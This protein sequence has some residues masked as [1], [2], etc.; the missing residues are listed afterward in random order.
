MGGMQTLHAV[1]S[2]VARSLR[3]ATGTSL[4]LAP[5]NCT[6]NPQFAC[7]ASQS[8]GREKYPEAASSSS[9][10]SAG[11]GVTAAATARASASESAMGARRSRR[12]GLVYSTQ[13][14]A[15][16][17]PESYP[18]TRTIPRSLC[19]SAMRS[20]AAAPEEWPMR[21]ASW[22]APSVPV[23]KGTQTFSLARRGSGIGC[24]L[25]CETGS[26]SSSSAQSRLAMAA[27][28]RD[29]FLCGVIGRRRSCVLPLSPAEVCLTPDVEPKSPELLLRPSL[30]VLWAVV[31]VLVHQAAPGTTD[32]PV[33]TTCTQTR[34]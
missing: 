13:Y 30:R 23:M 4:S 3:T 34:T 5:A 6:M 1:L 11:A 31:T 29:F 24:I 12:S 21:T 15:A 25:Q 16:D 7:I 9:P 2:G 32:A 17:A 27:G 18:A 20:A 14:A 10:K 26:V 33:F 22:S 28:A 8:N 19:F